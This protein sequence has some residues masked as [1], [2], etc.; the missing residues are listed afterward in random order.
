MCSSKPFGEDGVVDGTALFVSGDVAGH[1]IGPP[2]VP[3]TLVLRRRT[4]FLVCLRSWKRS[5]MLPYK[6]S[7]LK[8]WLLL[9]STQQFM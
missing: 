2:G 4:S 7:S 1:V 6:E 9:S 3:T 8:R 5:M